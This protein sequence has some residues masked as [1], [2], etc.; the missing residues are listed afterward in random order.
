MKDVSA[1]VTDNRQPVLS[2]E[3]QAILLVDD[4]DPC[5]QTL[6][7]ML[8]ALGY[9]VRSV[10]GGW[11]ALEIFAEEPYGFSLVI[12]DHVMPDL[13]GI[14]AARLLLQI[15]PDIPVLLVTGWILTDTAKQRAKAVGI[16]RILQKPVS[17]QELDRAMRGVIRRDERKLA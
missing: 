2:G 12:L 10:S 4:N 16:R 7:E 1:K 3:R 8:M 13:T 9:T 15:R 14:N 11:E 5:L 17:P 6:S